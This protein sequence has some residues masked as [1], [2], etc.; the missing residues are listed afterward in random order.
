LS[1]RKVDN[2]GRVAVYMK[3]PVELYEILERLAKK[4]NTTKTEIFS[5]WLERFMPK[6]RR[7]RAQ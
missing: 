4:K 3:I 2:A 7:G 1:K 5:N 6:R